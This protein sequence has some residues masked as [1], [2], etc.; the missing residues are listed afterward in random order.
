MVFFVSVS[1]S[2]SLSVLYRWKPGVLPSL[3][4]CLDLTICLCNCISLLFIRE[5][6]FELGHVPVSL[7]WMFSVSGC[8]RDIYPA[9]PRLF[10]VR[11]QPCRKLRDGRFLLPKSNSQHAA[12]KIKT[13]KNSTTVFGKS[14]KPKKQCIIRES[15][16]GLVDGNDEFYH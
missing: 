6:F 3:Y 12:G 4:I 13:N 2:V 16:T 7:R 11:F 1:V 9:R 14:K 10:V 15:N 5:G 8:A